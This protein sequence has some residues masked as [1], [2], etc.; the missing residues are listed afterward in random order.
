MDDEQI[1]VVFWGQQVPHVLLEV[2]GVLVPSRAVIRRQ[3]VA[4]VRVAALLEELISDC[5]A[6]LAAYE[7][8]HGMSIAR[9]EARSKRIVRRRAMRV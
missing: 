3:Q 4:G 7:D 8:S 9:P 2:A 6:E 5:S 1:P